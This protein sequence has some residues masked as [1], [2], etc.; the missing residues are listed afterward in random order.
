MYIEHTRLLEI[1]SSA[2]RRCNARA[3]LVLVLVPILVLHNRMNP[4]LPRLRGCAQPRAFFAELEHAMAP[5]FEIYIAPALPPH[6][7]L[8]LLPK[9]F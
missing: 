4:I 7:S 9:Y 6:S 5:P 2:T 3:S 1:E 8:V